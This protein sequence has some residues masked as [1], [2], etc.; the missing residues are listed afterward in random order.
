MRL[1]SVFAKPRS[2]IAIL[3][4]P[5]HVFEFANRRY[6]E[7]VGH[8]PVVGKPI[9]RRFPTSPARG[10]T[11]CSIGSTDRGSRIV[12]RS[13]RQVIARR[14]GR[15]ETFFDFVY[16]PLF[17]DEGRVTGIAVVAFDVTELTNA[18]RD[19]E[20]ANRAKDEFLAMLGHELRNPLAPILTALQLMRLRGVAGAE[21][22]RAIIE[23]QVTHMVALVDDL[24]DVSR[25]TRGKV[26]ARS[27]SSS[28][29]RTSSPRRSRWPVR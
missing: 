21:R 27:A 11:S 22:E 6:L 18:Q 13:L 1:A 12:G 14:G 9:R 16:Q 8:R 4:G 23:R 10:S 2:A 26:A 5:E 7:L 25:I 19:A 28:T 20:S 24:L 3:R 17:D 15:E 29:W